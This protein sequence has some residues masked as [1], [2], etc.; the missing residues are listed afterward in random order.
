MRPAMPHGSSLSLKIW[1]PWQHAAIG[2]SV[3]MCPRRDG[4]AMSWFADHCRLLLDVDGIVDGS[5]ITGTMRRAPT[6]SDSR[7]EVRVATRTWLPVYG[8]SM[9]LVLPR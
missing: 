3:N 4:H 9:I 8:A 7:A 6:M 5:G 2:R 1:C